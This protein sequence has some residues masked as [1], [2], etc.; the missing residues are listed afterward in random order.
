MSNDYTTIWVSRD[1]KQKLDT[2]IDKIKKIVHKKT[3]SYDEILS[4]VLCVKSLDQQ[5]QDYILEN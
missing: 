3:I 5:L 1:N 4:I 2:L